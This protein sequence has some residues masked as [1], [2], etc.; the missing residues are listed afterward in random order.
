[1]TCRG[2]GADGTVRGALARSLR[3]GEHDVTP[4]RERSRDDGHTRKKC[5]DAQKIE[6]LR[7]GEYGARELAIAHALG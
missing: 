6:V 5:S 4:F 3:G 1:M 7:R 2:L